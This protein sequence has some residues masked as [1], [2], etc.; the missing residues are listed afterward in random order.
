MDFTFTP[1]QDEAAE[2][3]AKILRDR[4]TNERMKAVEADGSR[5]DV[6]LWQDLADAGLLSLAIPEE[7]G[8]AGL[9]LVELCRVLVEVGR[10]VAPVPLAVHG[11]AARLLAE[12]GSEEQKSLWLFGAATGERVL[13][14]VLGQE[15]RRGAVH[16]QRPG[17]NPRSATASSVGIS[18][19]R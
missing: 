14:A 17:T 6:E 15:P 4:A 7:Y 8:G 5:F 18:T 11:P 9:G 13:T 3:A 1:E 16:R 2:L 12:H 19:R 10:T